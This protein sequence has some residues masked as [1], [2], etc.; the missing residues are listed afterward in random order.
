MTTTMM[1]T[2]KRT[3]TTKTERRRQRGVALILVLWTFAA[4]AVLAAEFARAMHDEVASTRNFKESS[5]ARYIA[6]AALS[7]T[8]LALKANRELDDTTMETGEDEENM[9]PIRSLSQGD[10]QWVRA[11]FRGHEYEVRVIDESGK[12]GLNFVTAD[13]L[14]LIFENLDYADDD[15][16]TIADSIV[17]WRDE[18]D[19][20]QPNGA[21]NDYYEG[22]PRPYRCKNAAFDSVDELLLVRGVTREMFYGVDGVPGLRELFSVFNQ[23]KNV[24][25]RSMTPAVMQALGGLDPED[26]RQ[27]GQDRRRTG[28][29]AVI[30]QL[31]AS[32][33][34]S[35]ANARNSVPTSMTIEARVHDLSGEVVLAHIGAVVGLS[36]S[37]D[38]LRVDR[39]YD[40]IFGD[41]ED[42]AEGSASGEASEES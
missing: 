5:A 20:H 22:L 4:L 1:T 15:A 25:L 29:E 24:N 16:E 2:R 12:L 8:M 11:A 36:S 30:D 14:R 31:R 33:S 39:W 13:Q 18:D 26:A 41:S 19:L 10:G 42:G 35:G 34:A 21:E 23:T 27:M 3:T 6:M 28:G 17:D 9:D 37:G 38:G 32:L 40:S 7:E